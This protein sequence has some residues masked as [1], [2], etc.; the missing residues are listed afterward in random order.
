MQLKKDNANAQYV[1]CCA[2]AL[3]LV[4]MDCTACCKVAKDFL[5]L[6]QT[7]AVF[8]L[9]SYKRMQVWKKVYKYSTTGNQL[10]RLL[11]KVNATRWWS[12]DRALQSILD[13]P[14]IPLNESKQCL[15]LLIC[16][17]TI[18]NLEHFNA[19]ATF[20]ANSLV[21]NWCKFQNILVAFV[22][23]D[24][25]ISST[26]TSKYLQTNGIDL[27]TASKKVKTLQSEML[28]MRNNF[29]FIHEN[30]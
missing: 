24:M 20:Q 3:N 17:H 1:H 2:H 25:F 14:S 9:E 21:A 28:T 11:Q 27:L 5:G 22:F 29:D 12:K 30:A 26:Q 18:S 8:V 15:T 16:L 19:D 4:M 6:L 10:L 13:N 23:R 7:T